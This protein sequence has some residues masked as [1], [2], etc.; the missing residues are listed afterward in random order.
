MGGKNSCMYVILPKLRQHSNEMMAV[1][2]NSF[3]KF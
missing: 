2:V 1:T 3:Q